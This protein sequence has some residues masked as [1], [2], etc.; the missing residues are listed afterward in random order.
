MSLAAEVPAVGSR[1]VVLLCDTAPWPDEQALRYSP[2]E[3]RQLK[4]DSSM[5]LILNTSRQV[6]LM[7]CWF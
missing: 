7:T 4:C 5:M 6:C 3:R 1:P 2:N